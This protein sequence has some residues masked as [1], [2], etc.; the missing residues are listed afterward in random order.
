[1]NSVSKLWVARKMV[2]GSVPSL[3]EHGSQL[4]MSE[5][6]LCG[7]RTLLPYKRCGRHF[8]VQHYCPRRGAKVVRGCAVY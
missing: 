6:Q 5:T 1:M 3:V 2:M 7:F 4:V 8:G